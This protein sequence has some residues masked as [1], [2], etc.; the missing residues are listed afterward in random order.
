MKSATRYG[1]FIY[2]FML[3]FTPS[4]ETLVNQLQ[5]VLSACRERHKHT[6][7]AV[8]WVQYISVPSTLQID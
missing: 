3:Y 8:L 4:S 6:S 1:F 5:G 2:C 7:L